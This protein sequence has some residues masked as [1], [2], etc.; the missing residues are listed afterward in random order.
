MDYVVR[1]KGNKIMRKKISYIIV[2]WNNEEIIEECLTSLLKYAAYETE[3]IVV[4]NDSK[5]ATCEVIRNLGKNKIKIIETHANLGFSKAN[6]VGIEYA[7]GDYVFFVNPDVIFIEDII[8][9]MVKMLDEN[10][11][12]GVISPRLLY[13][14]GTFQVSCCNFPSAK[15]V[16]WD[17]FHLCKLCSE[18]KKMK[19][20]QAQYRGTKNHY[21]DWTYGAAHL[22]RM[23]DVKAV[24][25]YPE[26]YFMYGEDT[27]FC[28]YFKDKLNK[29]TY[30]LWDSRLIHL[31]GYSEKKVL[32][33]KK[34]V[35]GTNAAMYFVNKYYG[36]SACERYKIMLGLA[37]FLKMVVYTIICK[38]SCNQH[39]KNEKTK[40]TASLKTI[41]HYEGTQN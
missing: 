30:Y 9:P 12:I 19:L 28:M 18:E 33:S 26:G 37:S 40:W 11:N 16:L 31:G 35:Y 38:F 36:S 20:A 3:V 17:D 14:D 41:M 15:K 34:I 5:D 10:S 7:T 32:N 1:W 6:N 22:C 39:Y 24:G 27:E 25:G 29:D 13:R 8:T 23:E 21:V 4:D 2:T